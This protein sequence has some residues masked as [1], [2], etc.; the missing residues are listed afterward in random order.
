MPCSYC[1]TVNAICFWGPMPQKAWKRPAL[2]TLSLVLGS[3]LCAALWVLWSYEKSWLLIAL[4]ILMLL[5]SIL[6][7][8]VSFRGCEAC[9]ARLFGD[10]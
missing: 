4:G 10:A 9:V 3:G 6:G 2:R 1:N 8:L 7:A 5:I